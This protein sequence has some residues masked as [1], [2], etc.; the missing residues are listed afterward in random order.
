MN[1]VEVVPLSTGALSSSRGPGWT[2]VLDNAPDPSKLP[3]QPSTSKR[4]ARTAGANRLTASDLSLR[5]ERAIKSRIA[6]LDKDSTKDIPI[7]KTKVGGSGALKEGKTTATK[8]ILQSGRQ[9]A[10]WLADEEALSK[11]ETSAAPAK[12]DL[13]RKRGSLAQQSTPTTATPVPAEAAPGIVTAPASSTPMDVDSSELS[14]H[15]ALLAPAPE[16]QPPSKEELAALLSFPTLSYTAARAGPSEVQPQR[17]FCEVCGYWGRT[18]C[19][20]CGA[21]VCGIECRD[22]HEQSQCVRF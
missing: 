5:Q 1:R 12:Q 13:K 14:P 7:P 20:K 22:M 17:H 8:K 2:Y 9:F 21:R 6:E 15:E 3:I 19:M 4:A 18:R 11:A 10:H 16:L